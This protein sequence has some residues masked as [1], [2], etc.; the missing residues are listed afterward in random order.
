MVRESICLGGE[1]LR[2]EV[3]CVTFRL[4]KLCNVTNGFIVAAPD[5]REIKELA[6]SHPANP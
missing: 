3:T 5:C 2:F 6:S 1:R 4:Q